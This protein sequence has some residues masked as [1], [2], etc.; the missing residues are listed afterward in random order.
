M[1]SLKLAKAEKIAFNDA[2]ACQVFQIEMSEQRQQNCDCCSAT[3]CNLL[4]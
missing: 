2:K 1:E 3:H 4:P